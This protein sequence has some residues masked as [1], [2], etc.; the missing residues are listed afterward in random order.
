M[1]SDRLNRMIENEAL[2]GNEA[3]SIQTFFSDLQNGIFYDL[4][5]GSDAYTR[6]LQRMYVEK[7]I[8]VLQ[9]ETR[10]IKNSDVAPVVRGA[11]E[12]LKG[13]LKS[14]GAYNQNNIHG[15][16]LKDLVAR[17]ENMDKDK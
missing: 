9:S 1:V 6:N 16:H 2:N 11:L 10:S 13:S 17:I 8:S 12:K 5:S 15:M 3:Y 7:L 4:N 14:N